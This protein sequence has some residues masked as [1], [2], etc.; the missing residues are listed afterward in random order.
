MLLQ[1]GEFFEMGKATAHVAGF[2]PRIAP[3]LAT[4]G[5]YVTSRAFVVYG[6]G[7]AI[8]RVHEHGPSF[9]DAS[10]AQVVFGN[11][12]GDAEIHLAVGR[13][14]ETALPAGALDERRR[15]ATVVFHNPLDRNRKQD[16][17]NPVLVR[18]AQPVL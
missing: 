18:G 13:D 2:E 14:R 4:V 10:F 1:P 8:H 9:F 6:R 3:A 7:R 12:K 16:T 17:V 15:R 11:R 5:S